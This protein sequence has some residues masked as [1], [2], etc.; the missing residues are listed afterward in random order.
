MMN[1][2][3]DCYGHILRLLTWYVT[4]ENKDKHENLALK[5]SSL[6]GI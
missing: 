1:L 4:G 5:P 2:E 3:E 6:V